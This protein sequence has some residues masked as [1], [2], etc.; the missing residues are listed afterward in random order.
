MVEC[1]LRVSIKKYGDLSS[2]ISVSEAA[3]V[4]WTIDVEYYSLS[5]IDKIEL[6]NV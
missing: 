3:K 5:D 4:Q 1:F 6:R 2:G